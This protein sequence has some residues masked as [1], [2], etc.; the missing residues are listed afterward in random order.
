MTSHE[1]ASALV[2]IVD[3]IRTRKTIGNWEII[4]NPA[5]LLVIDVWYRPNSTQCTNYG[6]T[7]TKKSE[8]I[9]FENFHREATKGTGTPSLREFEEALHLLAQKRK[10]PI[11]VLFIHCEGQ[12][13]TLKWLEKNGYKNQ[14]KYIYP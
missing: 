5:G 10:T 12:Q 11:R 2:R 8:Y 7:I 6:F 4:P 1:I 3:E 13:D 14:E 9:Q